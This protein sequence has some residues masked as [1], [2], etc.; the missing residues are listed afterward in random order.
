MDVKT[1]G[2][3]AM[4]TYPDFDLNSPYTLDEG[5]LDVLSEYKE[6]TDEYDSKFSELLFTMWN[7]VII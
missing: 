1:G 7:S 4:A 6:G 3:L 2:I 5:S